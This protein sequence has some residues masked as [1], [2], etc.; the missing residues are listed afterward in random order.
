[1]QQ[2]AIA[3]LKPDD[4]F[5]GF[6]LVRSAEQRTSSK[7]SKYLDLTLC[8]KDS[9]INCKKGDGTVPPPGQGS[10]IKVAG[11]V[12]EFNGRLQMRIDQMRDARPDDMVDLSL[13]MPCAP[14]PAEDMLSEIN[15]TIDRMKTPE[16]QAILRELLN[17][18]TG[19][20]GSPTF[21]FEIPASEL[22]PGQ[23]NT[24][25]IANV[26]D[27]GDTPSYSGYLTFDYYKFTAKERKGFILMFR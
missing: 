12:Q 13:L 23:D 27:D 10:V 11:T 19:N 9:E 2:L 22:L 7:G 20:Q 16:L 15:R 14:E 17:M 1:M 25:Y 21:T 26:V 24:V 4:R 5:L 8:D 18:P 3:T 6:L